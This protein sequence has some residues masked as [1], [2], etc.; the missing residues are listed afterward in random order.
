MVTLRFLMLALLVVVFSVLPT[1]T[2]PAEAS[3]FDEAQRFAE[4]LCE[5]YLSC[6]E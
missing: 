1:T 6:E 5:T 4:Y 3:G 2:S